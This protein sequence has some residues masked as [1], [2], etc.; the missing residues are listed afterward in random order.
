MVQTPNCDASNANANVTYCWPITPYCDNEHT[1][2]G[3]GSGDRI[4]GCGDGGNAT[5]ASSRHT[6]GV[7]ALMCDG[8]VR[9]VADTVNPLTWFSLF[10]LRGGEVTA[11]F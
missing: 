3:I 8:S 10:S 11:D 4:L 6:G 2:V 9:F 1:V 7:N 5:R